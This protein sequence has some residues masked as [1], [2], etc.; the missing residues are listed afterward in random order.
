MWQRKEKSRRYSSGKDIQEMRW[1]RCSIIGNKLS[2]VLRYRKIQ[3][4]PNRVTF[5]IK[6]LFYTEIWLFTSGNKWTITKA[7]KCLLLW[8]NCQRHNVSRFFI[9]I[10]FYCNNNHMW[11]IVTN[12]QNKVQGSWIRTHRHRYILALT[13]AYLHR[14]SCNITFC[15]WNS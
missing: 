6:E 10:S 14:F 12:W 4:R 3:H 7:W 11:E 15:I 2:G 13:D 9:I 8:S 1:S 5:Y